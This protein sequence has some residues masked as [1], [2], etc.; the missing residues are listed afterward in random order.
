M[1]DDIDILARTL[2]GEAEPGDMQDLQAIANVVMNRVRNKRWPNTA[3]KVCRQRRQ[4]SCWDDGEV[5]AQPGQPWFEKC[6]AMAKRAVAGDLPDITHGS[7]HYYATYIAAP[8]WARGKEPVLA[9]KWGR[10]THLFFNDIDT[11]K[12]RTT[13]AAASVTAA[14]ATAGGLTAMAEQAGEVAGA[15]AP[16]I[17]AV[18]AL[19]P[20]LPWVLGAAALV[21]IG[22]LAWAW[23][24]DRNDGGRT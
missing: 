5:Q 11:P 22:W 2:Y 12:P 9:T 20:A 24:Q 18:K 21:G 17:E 13:V 10:Y 23:W 4:F 15:M 19:G 7:T 14:G 6:V 1:S 3:A 16:V 8:K